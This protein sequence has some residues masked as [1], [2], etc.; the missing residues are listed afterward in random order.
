MFMNKSTSDTDYLFT[1]TMELRGQKQ[2]TCIKIE[3]KL[4]VEHTDDTLPKRKGL[5][6]VN[7]QHSHWTHV[8]P[9]LCTVT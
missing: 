1:G 5:W 7:A 9:T 2:E 6:A 8:W 4:K 3:A